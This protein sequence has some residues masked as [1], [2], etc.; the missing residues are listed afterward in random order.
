[1]SPSDSLPRSFRDLYE[2][3]R[4]VYAR[5]IQDQ[6]LQAAASL[7]YAVLLSLVPLMTVALALIAAFPVFAEWT[8]ALEEF[9]LE[10]LL[11]EAIA[12][13]ITAHFYD[14]A[15]NVGRLTALGMLALTA[16]ALMVMLTI[17]STFNR[18]F[19]VAR[20]RPLIWQ[21]LIYW[22][23][24]TLGPV[25]L[26]ASLTMTSF[27]VTAS[28]GVTTGL[29][30]IGEVVL[31]FVP[32]VLT[33]LALTLMYLIVPNRR[34]PLRHAL[35]GGCIAGLAFELAKRGFTVYI[36]QFPTYRVI[37]GAFATI[38]IFLIWLYLSWLM[39]LLGAVIT[40]L[41]PGYRYSDDR[42]GPPGSRFMQALDLLG[43]LHAAQHQGEPL[44]LARLAAEVRLPLESCERLLDRM[45]ECRWVARTPE[46]AWVLSRDPEEVLIADVYRTFV[47]SPHVPDAVRARA[48]VDA[49]LEAH[50]CDM[51]GPLNVS[52]KAFFSKNDPSVLR[53]ARAA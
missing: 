9:M 46:D 48:N 49:L 50:R 43:R 25:L 5:F 19:R 41:L 7:T 40:A 3:L 10:N 42:R 13:T 30:V 53:P 14:F 33:I 32:I 18:I 12:D 4:A 45:R 20:P 52:L 24:L 31:E 2:F 17:D 44:A 22:A 16:T 39:V 6:C 51:A 34:V 1:M 11:P 23:V 38:P 29:P 26:G 21:V 36:A 37:Y 15:A 8:T 28:L 35:I 27:L 47:F